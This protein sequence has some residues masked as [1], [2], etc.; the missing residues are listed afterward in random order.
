MENKTLDQP[1]QSG[2]LDIK[3]Q[4]TWGISAYPVAGVRSVL[5]GWFTSLFVV[6]LVGFALSWS[7]DLVLGT[8]I[9]TFGL[10]LPVWYVAANLWWV[11]L[12]LMPAML[13]RTPGRKAAGLVLG[14][15]AVGGLAVWTSA[16]DTTTLSTRTP[17][18]PLP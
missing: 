16:L 10:M 6:A 7:G 9:V 15:A 3:R 18:L 8:S 4:A 5:P 12:A 17:A 1:E 11:M 2:D 13:G 14:V